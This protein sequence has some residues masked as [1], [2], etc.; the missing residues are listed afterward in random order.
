MFEILSNKIINLLRRDPF[1]FLPYLSYRQQTCLAVLIGMQ[2][3]CLSYCISGRS[4]LFAS[5]SSIGLTAVISVGE[6]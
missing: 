1:S 4:I 5:I 3:L 6:E 2:A